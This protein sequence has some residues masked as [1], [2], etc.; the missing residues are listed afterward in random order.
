MRDVSESMLPVAVYL[1][2]RWLCRQISGHSFRRGL[3]NLPVGH[4]GGGRLVVLGLV[5]VTRARRVVER[6]VALRSRWF[7]A[8]RLVLEPA[9]RSHLPLLAR[10]GIAEVVKTLIAVSCVVGR[11]PLWIVCSVHWSHICWGMSAR[12]WCNEV[13]ARGSKSQ[14]APRNRQRTKKS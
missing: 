14:R 7:V 13:K 3:T 2:Y 6:A 5:V 1:R 11:W 9:G 8:W 12:G 10:V 4:V